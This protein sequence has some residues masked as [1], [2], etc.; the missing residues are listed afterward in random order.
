MRFQT[1]QSTCGPTALFNAL[2]ALGV[3]RS[4]DEC[5]HLCGTT[6]E[7]TDGPALVRGAAKIPGLTPVPLRESR[8]DVAVLRLV[9]ALRAGRPVVL[10]VDSDEHWVAAVGLLGERVLVADSAD[11]ELVQSL[12]LSQLLERWRGTGRRPFYGVIL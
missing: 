4:L 5:E 9:A 6:T 11:N 3:E 10:A 12:P 1:N 2:V 8:P 7:G